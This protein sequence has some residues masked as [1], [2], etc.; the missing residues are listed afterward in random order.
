MNRT[1]QIEVVIASDQP[2][3]LAGLQYWFGSH[4][5]YGVSASVSS[6]EALLA[7]LD[8]T[9]AELIVMTCSIDSSPGESAGREDWP[10]LRDVR[11]RCPSTPV[12]VMTTQT[13]PASLRAMQAAGATGIAAHRDDP[14]EFERVCN[15]VMSGVTHVMSRQLAALC[16]AAASFGFGPGYR[17]VR[18]MVKPFSHSR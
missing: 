13:D 10:V 12:V 3:I 16:D 17:E 6:A 2:A 7:T 9:A 8:H 5:R 15:R 4:A 18:V 1:N 11:R 14:R